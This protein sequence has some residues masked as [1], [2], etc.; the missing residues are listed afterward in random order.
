VTSET[1]LIIEILFVAVTLVVVLGVLLPDRRRRSPAVLV[2]A[3]VIGGL[4]MTVASL[5]SLSTTRRVVSAEALAA[6]VPR[7][8]RDGDGFTGSG[9]CRACH[10]REYD[11][12]HASFHRTMT[13]LAT[14][15]TVIGDFDDV[16]LESGGRTTHLSRAGDEFWAEMVDPDWEH[17]VVG[18]GGD[19]DTLPD[20][21]RVRKR[22]VMTTGLHHY[23]VYWVASRYGRKLI[24]FPF[25][26]M[27]KERRWIP[28]EAAF[29]RPPSEPRFHQEWNTNC[30][31]CHS[32]AGDPGIDP[33]TNIMDTSVAELGITCEACHGPAE[34]HAN[35]NANPARR[36]GLLMGDETD[37][38]IVQPE[39][40]DARRS[41]QVCG[42]C[43]S[44]N[45]PL[46]V[47][48]Q[49]DAHFHAGD[50]L[51][52][53]A[54]VIRGTPDNLQ[55]ETERERWREARDMLIEMDPDFMV[56][57][58]W[59]DG[60]VRISGRD[61]NGLIESPCYAGG[62]LSCLSCHS[63]HDGDPN[64]QL[65][66]GM[67]TDAA[68]LQCHEDYADEI[69]THTHHPPDSSGSSCINCHMP[70]TTFGLLKAI[71]SHQI[72]SPTIAATLETGRP[73]ACN[74]CHLDR[75]L[76]WAADHLTAWYDQ[77]APKLTDDDHAIAAA[78]TWALQG[79]AG[80]RALMAWAIGWAPAQEA[81]GADWLAP[82]LA[83]LL[84]DPYDA[85]R[86]VAEQS[87]R[88]FPG[89]ADI[90]YDFVADP[91]ARRAAIDE[92]L[93]RWAA[94][95]H[96]PNPALLINDDGTIDTATWMRLRTNRDERDVELLE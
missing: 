41:S 84:D 76:G 7:I 29:L 88:T 56:D 82:V 94:L 58:Y 46:V 35:A 75:S 2:I 50:D 38:T 8:G 89:S 96:T 37:D 90:A 39:R 86:G 48:L 30:I 53:Y 44:I 65:A 17:R 85:V 45:M 5:K 23:Q 6:S 32:V 71:R 42:Q 43:H 14:P 27:S 3:I 26:Y 92:F 67:E 13:Q 4:T 31:H 51:D 9:R 19:P 69:E 25:A 95:T 66:A 22:I 40:L 15:E 59:S 80:Q 28:R 78:V 64:D 70:H 77:P 81:S 60:M 10:A 73:D 18:Q 87:L 79:D 83:E 36:Y 11:T 72:D 57:R 93:R 68:C 12:W 52:E 62:E 91:P 63:L 34:T 21:P 49:A 54:Y 33:V 61:Y 47:A 24:N 16:T 1:T 20:P 74:L 55:T